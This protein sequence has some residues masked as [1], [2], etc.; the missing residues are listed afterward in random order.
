[1]P[2][3]SSPS[4]RAKLGVDDPWDDDGFW[5]FRRF[6][7]NRK[8]GA[9]TGGRAWRRIVRAREDRRVKRE[10]QDER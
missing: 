4:N 3:M 9:P 7:G 8:G 10:I 6:K 5:A 2:M 1:M